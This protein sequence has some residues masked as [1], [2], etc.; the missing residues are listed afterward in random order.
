MQTQTVEDLSNLTIFGI[1]DRI[2][3]NV[4]GVVGIIEQQGHL[5]ILHDQLPAEKCSEVHKKIIGL[6]QVADTL[7]KE[8]EALIEKLRELSREDLPKYMLNKR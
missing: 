6:E 3:G 8:A 4:Q 5:K 1:R 7:L 2:R